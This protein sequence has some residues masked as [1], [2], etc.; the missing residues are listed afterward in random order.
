M[1]AEKT[2]MSEAFVEAL[3]RRQLA[4]SQP[5]ATAAKPIIK[6]I[7]EVR[8]PPNGFVELPQPKAEAKG[9]VKGP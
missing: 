2:S 7:G 8:N 1:S 9:E 4:G 6:G 5:G 3:K